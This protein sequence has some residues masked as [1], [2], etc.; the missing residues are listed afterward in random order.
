[1]Q[2][3]LKTNIL[4]HVKNKKSFFKSLCK[5]RLVT[6]K[7]KTKTFLKPLSVEKEAFALL[8]NKVVLVTN[9]QEISSGW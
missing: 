5:A 7:E 9:V 1:M 4:R 3:K 8:V 2:R 6:E